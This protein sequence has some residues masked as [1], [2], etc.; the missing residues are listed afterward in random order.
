MQTITVLKFNEKKGE[1]M[2]LTYTANS[3]YF[4]FEI[5]VC[6]DLDIYPFSRSMFRMPCIALI[7]VP[8]LSKTNVF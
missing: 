2:Q 1:N 6:A 3:F 8:F 5:K 4:I 7:L